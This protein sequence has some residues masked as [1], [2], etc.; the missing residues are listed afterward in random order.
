MKKIAVLL[1]VAA[2]LGVAIQVW[3]LKN[4]AESAAQAGSAAGI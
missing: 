3:C 2:C 1:V 4:R